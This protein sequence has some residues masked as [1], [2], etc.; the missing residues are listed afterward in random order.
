MRLYGLILYLV[1]FA[2]ACG[3]APAP[4]E[5]AHQIAVLELGHWVPD[6][7]PAVVAVSVL[8]DA[9]VEKTGMDRQKLANLVYAFKQKINEDS[10]RNVKMV[11][12]LAFA[13][14]VDYITNEDT[15]RE[16]L[17]F[18]GVYDPEG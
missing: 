11:E 9:V 12:L 17:A 4:K 1:V 10:T 2:T 15:L 6:D 16:S 18:Y 3:G 8:L 5:P 7:D 13:A 14:Q